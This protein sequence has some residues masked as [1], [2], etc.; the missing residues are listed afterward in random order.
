M[1]TS[2][3]VAKHSTRVFKAVIPTWTNLFDSIIKSVFLSAY[4]GLSMGKIF[5]VKRRA[6]QVSRRREFLTL[7][8][9]VLCKRLGWLPVCHCRAQWCNAFL[10][11]LARWWI[12]ESLRHKGNNGEIGRQRSFTFRMRLKG[13]M[14]VVKRKNASW[15]LLWN[16]FFSFLSK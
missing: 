12:K 15:R 11:F 10:A 7:N 14:V 5:L 4:S 16:G 6:N 8:P 1:F 9:N 2:L 3:H 13:V